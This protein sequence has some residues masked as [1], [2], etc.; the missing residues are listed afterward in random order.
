MTVLAFKGV[1]PVEHDHRPSHAPE[2]RRPVEPTRP[3][4]RERAASA[5]PVPAGTVCGQRPGRLRMRWLVMLGAAVFAAV[6]GLGLFADA[7]VGSP[8]DALPQTTAVVHVGAGE[9]LWEVASRTLPDADTSAVVERI[10]ELNRLGNAAVS[11]GQPL[12][13]PVRR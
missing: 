8:E 13:V 1:E 7:V 2:R 6:V 5:P 12:T 3:P 10:K 11:P 9:S 4:T